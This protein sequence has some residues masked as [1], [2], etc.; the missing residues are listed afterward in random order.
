VLFQRRSAK[1]RRTTIVS[2]HIDPAM[3]WVAQKL[4]LHVA[5]PLQAEKPQLM[6][7]RSHYELK[8]A[9]LRRLAAWRK[10]A[11]R[12]GLMLTRVPLAGSRSG[13]PA[14]EGSTPTWTR[15]VHVPSHAAAP[16]T[17]VYDPEHASLLRE[18]AELELVLVARHIPGRAGVGMLA[19]QALMFEA[20]YGRP[21]T[22]CLVICGELEP[23]IA[24][25]YETIPRKHGLPTIRVAE[26]G[27]IDVPDDD[28]EED[29]DD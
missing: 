12:A 17:V 29:T 25:A 7:S 20:Q 27:P 4:D 16:G 2:R 10:Q 13:V 22:S 24:Y 18:S 23:A 28:T 15:F 5:Q 11:D 19:S 6:K 8:D 21:F 1:I 26:V 14:W 9:Q 3:R